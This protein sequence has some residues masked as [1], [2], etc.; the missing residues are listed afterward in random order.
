M[1]L[2]RTTKQVDHSDPAGMTATYGGTF[3]DANG[4]AVSNASW[5]FN[6]DMS[7]VGAFPAQYWIVTGDDVTLMNQAQRDAVD[8]AALVAQRDAVA[9]T[10]D[11]VEGFARAF[12]LACLDEFNAHATKINAILTAIDNGGTLAAVKTNILA[13][14]DYPQR[15]VANLKTALR[16]QLGP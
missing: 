14:A 11:E 15:T 13:I 8:A 7:A 16:N 2:N 6:P 12:A 5:I 1:W 3:V 4:G 10:I 9:A